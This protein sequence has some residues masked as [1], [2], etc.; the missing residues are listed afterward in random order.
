MKTAQQ[1]LSETEPAKWDEYPELDLEL[2]HMKRSEFRRLVEAIQAD[3]RAQGR[4]EGIEAAL[5]ACVASLDQ[6]DTTCTVA[7]RKLLEAKR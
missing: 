5:A 2:P 1:W 7:I 3:A 4:R 6:S